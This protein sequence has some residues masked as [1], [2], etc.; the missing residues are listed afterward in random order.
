MNA[1]C[2]RMR[3]GQGR[4]PPEAVARSAGLDASA[5]VDHHYQL[6]NLGWRNAENSRGG[7]N[8]SGDTF[9]VDRA[10]AFRPLRRFSVASERKAGQ[11]AYHDDYGFQPIVVFDGEGRFVTAV[12]RPGKRPSGVEIWCFERRLVGVIRAHWVEILLRADSHYAA[13]EVFD[14]CRVNRVDWIF[15]LAPNVALCRHVMALAKSTTER[16]NLAP[17]RGKQTASPSSTMAPRAGAGS[18]ASSPAS[19]RDPKAPTPALFS[20]RPRQARLRA[21]LLRPRPS[22]EPHQG[23][24]EP[25]RPRPHLL[26][27]GRGQPV[28]PVP[29]RWRLLA[30]VVDAPRHA[31]TFD[32]ASYAV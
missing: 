2:P 26:P 23:V 30:L 16:F 20:R 4:K 22:R 19:K 25:P 29:A 24:E 11:T 15:G 5:A 17:T 13:P 12:L 6:L 27:C 18:S 8:H 31:Q 10:R 14:W 3:P 1:R 9:G 21:A 32:L 28:S 7:C